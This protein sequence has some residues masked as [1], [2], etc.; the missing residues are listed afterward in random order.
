MERIVGLRR[1]IN[2]RQVLHTGR[3]GQFIEVVF[4]PLVPG[5]SRDKKLMDFEE[6]ERKVEKRTTNTGADDVQPEG[7]GRSR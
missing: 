2:G 7:N 6:Y 4:A 5:G 1:F 3:K